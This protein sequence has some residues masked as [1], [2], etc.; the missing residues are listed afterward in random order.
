LIKSSSFRRIVIFGVI[1]MKS[2]VSENSFLYC[3]LSFIQFA[4]F[5]KFKCLLN[6]I[7]C[8]LWQTLD[9]ELKML[10]SVERHAEGQRVKC[11]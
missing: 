11:T 6:V 5:P 10:Q 2:R 9:L 4:F 7:E 3:S 8:V 1:P